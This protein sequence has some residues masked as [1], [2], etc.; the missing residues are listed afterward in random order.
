MRV[1]SIGGGGAALVA[2]RTMTAKNPEIEAVLL[3]RRDTAG[4]R[5][6][7]LTYVLAG[8]IKTFEEIAALTDAE[9]PSFRFATTATAI[10]LDARSVTAV[11][12]EGATQEHA[13]DKLLLAMGASPFLPPIDGL[14]HE[15]VRARTVAPSTDMATFRRL[16]ELAADARSAVVV[17]AGAIGLEVAEGLVLRG[18]EV[19][20]VEALPRPL[21]RTFDGAIA[22]EVTRVMTDASVDLRFGAGL[23]SVEASGDGPLAVHTAVGDT[24]EADLLVVCAGFRPD[25][26]IAAAAGIEL[27]AS[28]CIATDQYRRTSAEGVYAIGD[29]ADNFNLVTERPEPNMLAINAVVT[30]KI[31]GHNIALGDTRASGGF[32]PSIIV[33]LADTY[34]GGV[35][36][37]DEQA[38]AGGF[39]RASV[40]HAAPGKPKN[41]GG[42]PVWT[43]LIA[44]K[45]TGRLLGAQMWSRESVAGELDRLALAIEHR[46]TVDSLSSSISCYTPAVTMP[47]T[48]VAQTLDRLLPLL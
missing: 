47:Y 16:C 14:E 2:L 34:F 28:G 21:A 39:D 38:V 5:P 32:V 43:K 1:V 35:G 7:E 9:I 15:A 25:V 13:F 42:V 24:V 26:G 22:G 37:T 45:G 19:T 8:Y 31:A 48:P 10:D 33:R 29:C 18:L 3:T 12:L 30:G 6:C 40:E 17:G 20:V 11:D 41:L 36:L 4:Y 27:G 23:A 46:L 44:E